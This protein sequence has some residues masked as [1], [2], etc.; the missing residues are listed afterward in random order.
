MR[1]D[2]EGEEKGVVMVAHVVQRRGEF[3]ITLSSGFALNVQGSTSGSKGVLVV[4]C[5]HTL[6]EVRNLNILYPLA[7]ELMFTTYPVDS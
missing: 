1:F 7:L 3:K 2:L 6:E 4:S 5:A